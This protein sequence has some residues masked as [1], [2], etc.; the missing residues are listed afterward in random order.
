MST[1]NLRKRKRVVVEEDPYDSHDEEV[2]HSPKRRKVG[3][4]TPEEEEA[5]KNPPVQVEEQKKVEAKPPKPV[6][7]KAKEVSRPR[8]TV[9]FTLRAAPVRD[10]KS[11][12]NQV[13]VKPV[14]SIV[15][16]KK[17]VLV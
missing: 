6:E 4:I 2:V 1:R 8:R 9:E 16:V 12:D 14:W 17:A 15:S 3:N 10:G 11:R 7:V 5:L 13:Y